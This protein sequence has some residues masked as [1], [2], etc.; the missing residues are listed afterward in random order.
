MCRQLKANDLDLTASGAAIIYTYDADGNKLRKQVASASINNEYI[1]GINYE[2]G[3]LKFVSTAEGRVVRN[4]A[5]SYSYEYTLTDHLGNGRVY[6]DINGAA[7]RKIQEVDYYAFGLDMQRSLN[8][9]EN[10]YLYNGKEK[11]DQE[12]MFDY[13]ARFYDPVIGRWNVIDPL[14][15]KM[16]RFSPYTYAFENPIRYTDPDGMKPQDIIFVVRG[17]EGQKD[18]TLVYKN[19][20]AY[21]SDSGK[22]YEF[23]GA[24]KTIAKVLKSFQAIEKSNDGALKDKLH[25]LENSKNHHFIEA[26]S[27]GNNRVI[28]SGIPDEKGG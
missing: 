28:A 9:T 26:G 23:K 5:T 13:G 7:A 22:K 8:G 3:V 21:W 24:N 25:T 10:K 27:D 11:Q 15:E 14:A 2:G 12:K 1:S 4:G 6:F 19:G 20:N 17:N 16:R 18:R